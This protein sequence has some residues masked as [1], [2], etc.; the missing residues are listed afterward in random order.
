MKRKIL[1]KEIGFPE[2]EK[3]VDE[4][5]FDFND[6]QKRYDQVKELMLLQELDYLIVYGDQRLYSNIY[7]LTGVD[8]KFEQALLIIGLDKGPAFITGIEMLPL[9]EFSP[10]KKKIKGFLYEPFSLQGMPHG[11]SF[12][13]SLIHI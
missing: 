10:Y 4:F 13:L 1:A 7:H 11:R 6:Y 2:I 5:I 9:L 8:L 3:P 12:D